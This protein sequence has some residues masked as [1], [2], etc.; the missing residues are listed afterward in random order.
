MVFKKPTTKCHP[1][2]APSGASRITSGLIHCLLSFMRFFWGGLSPFSWSFRAIFFQFP[3]LSLPEVR[4][5]PASCLLL[6]L[7]FRWLSWLYHSCSEWKMTVHEISQYISSLQN[8]QTHLSCL[9]QACQVQSLSN[10]LSIWISI[11]VAV[12]VCW[13]FVRVL[14]MYINLVVTTWLIILSLPHKI[15]WY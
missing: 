9:L 8:G 15:A 2:F 1:I 5:I 12:A 10:R 13:R 3:V 11:R 4:P 14:N 7:K 6:L